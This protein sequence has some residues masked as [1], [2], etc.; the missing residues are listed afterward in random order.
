MLLLLLLLL[1]L[2]QTPP[3]PQRPATPQ[4]AQPARPAPTQTPARPTFFTS[5]LPASELQN[6]QAVLETSYGVIV[7]DLL[8]EA[9]PNHVAFFITRARERAFDGTTFHRVISRGVIQ[10]GDPLSRDPAQTAQYGTGGLRQLRFEA[11]AEKHTRGAVSAV[12]I[13]GERDS[14]G[15]QF[16][17]CVSDQPTL[18]GQY[19]VFARVAEGISVAEKISTAAAAGDRPNERIVIKAVTIRDKPAPVP[20]PFSTESAT[21]LGQTHVVLETSLGPITL[22]FFPDKAPNHV[23]QFLRLA[24][25]GAFDGTAFHRV[26][27]GFVIQGGYLATRAAPLDEKQQAFVRKLQPEFNDRQH[28][29]GTLSMARG[30]DPASADTSFFIVL[31][32]AQSL[33]GKYTV[34]GRVTAGLEVIDKIAGAPLD[35]ETPRTRAEVLRATVTR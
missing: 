34:F 33:D 4:P 20:E 11:N 29:R 1:G 18:D 5:T 31:D 26:V 30:D 13:P 22:E 19:T 23:R 10:G 21:E 12:L 35:G 3:R 16:F 2:P 17:I 14:A 15:N 8:A 24:S 28:E 27:P 9:A 25:S 7:L 32:R 6:K